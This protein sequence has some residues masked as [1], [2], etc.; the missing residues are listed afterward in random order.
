MKN[1]FILLLIA[2]S[3]ISYADTRSIDFPYYQ[4]HNNYVME[5]RRVEAGNDTT[6]LIADLYSRPDAWV[7][8]NSASYL[9]GAKSGKVASLITTE[10]L[11]PDKETYPGSDGHISFVMKFEAL[12]PS[13]DSFD[14]IEGDNDGSF[15][16]KGVSLDMPLTYGDVTCHLEGIVSDSLVS[17]LIVLENSED[18]R[19]VERF[20]SIP[21]VNGQF[22]YDLHT[23]NEVYYVLFPYNEYIT[24]S[25]RTD[26]FF[27]Y[28]GTV[29][30]DV[31]GEDKLIRISSDQPDQKYISE[32]TEIMAS[33]MEMLHSVWEAIGTENQYTADGKILLEK[34]KE[35]DGE[36]R[37]N[38]YKQLSEGDYF[39]PEYKAYR[40]KV[41]S[42]IQRHEDI[43][44][45]W[46]A[47][48]PSLYSIVKVFDVLLSNDNEE[49]KA[50]YI[51]LYDSLLVNYRPDYYYHEK[52]D[53]L[54]RAEQ[55]KPG[56][57]YVDYDVTVG[58]GQKK[59]LSEL[60]GGH[61]TLV[62]LWA[63]WC[64]PC[65]RL[66]ID[67]I[68]VYEKYK[69]DGFQVIGIAREQSADAMDATVIDDGYTWKNYLELNDEN[70]IWMLN[71]VGNAGGTS[72]LID[73]NG[74]IL[75]VHP[76]AKDLEQYLGILKQM[77]LL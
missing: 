62:N 6:V 66:S 74:K 73:K 76:T 18:F 42:I 35:A 28:D 1:I 68:P 55:L 34:I 52:I 71:G 75:M 36:E 24:G 4:S 17:R 64:G 32:I 5:I 51:N 40:V 46:A 41:D 45:R 12:D 7:R 2:V 16:I 33:D 56:K 57:Q 39:S 20:V 70:N 44:M 61:I 65:R 60:A 67:Y 43:E 49:T 38:L 53:A 25:W 63:S 10:G 21:V 47:D 58:D 50:K 23:D 14:F 26:D 31:P 8:I 54:R 22:S 72:F 69:E 19:T 77:D 30:I 9:R 48:S 3:I 37:N 11:T 27:A 15:K 13:D 59:R 29:R